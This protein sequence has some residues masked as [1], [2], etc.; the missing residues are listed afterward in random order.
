MVREMEARVLAGRVRAL[1]RLRSRRRRRRPTRIRV[2]LL[3]Q[4]LLD[5]LRLDPPR[6]R[7][8]L[9]RLGRGL[10]LCRSSRR[11]RPAGIQQLRLIIIK[12]ARRRLRKQ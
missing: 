2:R 11:H 10:R 7:R 6:R 9:R 3:R 12:I 5:R 8:R 1:V 4:R